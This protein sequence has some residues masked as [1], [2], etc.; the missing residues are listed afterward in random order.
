MAL[1]PEFCN[2]IVP[3]ENIHVKLG[4]ETFQRQFSEITTVTWQDGQFFRD[5]CMN[6]YDLNACSM[7]GRARALSCFRWSM[8]GSTGRISVLS[9]QGM[10]HPNRCEWIEY[11]SE[12]NIVWLKGCE[13]SVPVG[14]L[15][16]E[17]AG[18]S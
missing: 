15:G 1:K 10:V 7:S 8:K 16:R 12:E 17:I 13:P 3:V 9:T 2:V 11:D 6:H 18:E 5:G 4:D 14:P